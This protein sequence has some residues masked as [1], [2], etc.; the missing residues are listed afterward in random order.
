MMSKKKIPIEIS[1]RH[2][3]LSRKDLEKLYGKD[4]KLKPV[5][6]LSQK[7]EFAS[8]EV[9]ELINERSK[10]KLNA[11]ILGPVR[12]E[13]Q[14]EISITDAYNLKLKQMPSLRV[15]GD[16]N[17]TSSIIIK[18]PKGKIKAKVIIAERHLHCNEEEAKRLGLKNNQIVKI[19][20]IGKRGLIFDNVIVRIGKNYKLALHLDTDEGNAAGILNLKKNYGELIK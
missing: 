5:H 6:F 18:G 14:A 3:H 13:S 20:I 10:E 12:N 17:G 16:L 7:G 1:A 8:E 15:S 11:R 4:Y 2:I 19:K 9:V